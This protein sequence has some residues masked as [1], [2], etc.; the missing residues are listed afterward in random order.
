VD[1]G[2]DSRGPAWMGTGLA[3]SGVD[4]DGTH[5][6]LRGWGRA[7][8]ER[9]CLEDS[10]AHSSCCAHVPSTWELCRDSTYLWPVETLL[11]ICHFLEAYVFMFS[12]NTSSS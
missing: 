8:V 6:A 11:A 10:T 1:G 7:H 5:V 4:G 9:L 12:G 2:Q 3:W